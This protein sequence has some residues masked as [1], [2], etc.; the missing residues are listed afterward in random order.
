MT[1]LVTVFAATVIF[2]IPLCLVLGMAGLAHF[3]SIGKPVYFNVM[4]QRVFAGIDNIGLSC[5]PF[6]IIAGEVM[7]AG[8]VTKK[9]ITFVREIIGF[10]RGGLAYAAVIMLK[11]TNVTDGGMIGPRMPAEATKEAAKS[12]G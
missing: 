5:I 12:S 10:T 6:F 7:N 8:G 11:K 9:L 2:G 4:I 1:L 3:I